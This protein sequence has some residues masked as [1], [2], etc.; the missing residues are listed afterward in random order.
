M[1]LDELLTGLR[2]KSDIVW[3][4][5][6]IADAALHAIR[7]EFDASSDLFDRH[8]A[9]SAQIGGT[10]SGGLRRMLMQLRDE[11][12]TQIRD[13]AVGEILQAFA[14]SLE[15]GW[16]AWLTK[17]AA[18][19]SVFHHRH[20]LRLCEHPFPFDGSRKQRVV[21]L[22]QAVECMLQSRWD[23][24]YEQIAFLSKQESLPDL[25]RARLVIIA[26]QIETSWFE[27]PKQAGRS[28]AEA[29]RLAPDDGL[30]LATLGD[31]WLGKDI[32]RAAAY[33]RR[34]METAP[35]SA[36]G[37][38][39]MGDR[40]EKDGRL[41]EAETWY[42]K[43]ISLAGGD[44]LGYN[45]LLRLLGR[46]ENLKSR[47]EEFL[48]LVETTLAVDPEGDY[49]TCLDTG[50][51]Y[52]TSGRFSEAGEWYDK[53]ISLHLNWPRAY[54]TLSALS[55]A[56]DNEEE[57]EANCKKAIEVAP[58]CPIGYL[59][60]AKI[61]EE[62]SRWQDALNIYEGSPQRSPQSASFARVMEG[63]MHAKLDRY[64][65]A[66]RILSEELRSDVESP[67]ALRAL[68]EIATDYDAKGGDKESAR[69]VYGGIREILGETYEGS[70][71][72]W[73]GNM[74]YSLAEYD[75][76]IAEYRRAIAAA[77]GEVVYHRNLANACEFLKDYENAEKA[78]ES[79][80]EIDNDKKL[81][82]QRR[83]G[84]ANA[85]GNDA[86][87]KEDYF[88]A[89]EQYTNAAVLDGTQAV[90]FTNCAWAWE[91][92]KKTGDR[93]HAL[94][95]A[96]RCYLRAQELPPRTNYA[97]PIARLRRRG[98]FA[99]AYGEKALDYLS[100]VTPIAVEV[101][102]D[103]VH[104]VEGG[105]EGGL[106]PELSANVSSMR[107]GVLKQLG[108][109]VPGIRFRGSETD[110]APGTYIVE[111]NEIPLLSGNLPPGCRFCTAS[112]E[113]LSCFGVSGRPVAD[114]ISGQAGTWIDRE[115]W[116]KVESAK[117]EL[118]GIT[119]YLMHHVEAELRKNLGEFLGHQETFSLLGSE[120]A[121]A[122]AEI[123]AS[124][125][126]VTALT[127][128]CQALVAEEVPIQPFEV[129]CATFKELSANRVSLCDVVEHIR[130]LP[131]FRE[132]L[133]GNEGQRSYLKLS[134][135]FEAEI[136][137]GIY[138][139]DGQSIL[140]MEPERCQAALAAVRARAV[141]RHLALVVDAALRP[142]VRKLVEL[143]FRDLPVLSS[144]EVRAEVVPESID[145][146]R[147]PA[148]ESLDLRSPRRVDANAIGPDEK[149]Q[150]PA[151]SEIEVTIFT[152]KDF[153]TEPSTA[154]NP[155]IG[156]MLSRMQDDLFY[157]LG[158]VLPQVK[159]ET[160][161]NWNQGEFRLRLNG[162][163]HGPFPGLGQDEFLVNDT[164]DRLTLL[165]IEG[166]GAVHPTNGSACAIVC[167][168][169]GQAATCRQAGLT[170]SGPRR[171]L[172]LTLSSEIRLAAARFQTDEVTQNQL[173]SLGESFPDLVRM[174]LERYTLPQISLLLRELLAEEISIRD[175]R[176]ILESLL[177]I[178]GTTDVD[179]SRFIV[180]FANTD[181]LCPAVAA[182]DVNA[183]TVT[184]LADFVRACLK[185]SISHK[186]TR[187]SNTLLVY[188]LDS[189]IEERIADTGAHPLTDEERA[190]LLKA[191]RGEVASLPPTAASPVLLTSFEVRRPLRK[192]IA[193]D[194]P[195]LAVL[196]YQDLSPD[197]NIQP[198]VRISWD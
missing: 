167:D 100:V 65:E 150:A 34:A 66:E 126:M 3:P 29:E 90:Y 147:T 148:A 179:L 79:A 134:T 172:V 21:E 156:E 178:G 19:V 16:R 143:E 55:Q 162:V 124:S 176:S 110:L 116:E 129:L 157:E 105:A 138:E 198:I 9:I 24:A 99:R 155:L 93:E 61:Y 70:Y 2:A 163:E 102:S 62:K 88:E 108:V 89:K 8:R 153:A 7:T 38:T 12:E 15:D 73:L 166:R 137:R 103:L 125:P 44:S 67:H 87:E 193:H 145:L 96:I 39:G 26:G 115:D 56:Q 171:H 191:I 20:S 17:L 37:Y 71:R 95:E 54:T 121:G 43:A 170:T 159:L 139:R 190:K 120:S 173:D 22:R 144:A 81:L 5:A 36:N 101:A 194:F 32:E 184:Q 187:G 63:R 136:R 186:Y 10:A 52:Q 45:Q 85:Q 183:L 18:A 130:G 28:Y 47:E 25:V 1:N 140:A 6:S 128:V 42:R 84:L 57:A 4:D 74:H 181:S 141:G 77:P 133:P 160:D 112:K 158:I 135:G 58:D 151:L 46:P 35:K 92:L 33:Y 13:T 196:S 80:C 119:K 189:A 91:R 132:R 104:C 152:G 53:A 123:R 64:Q 97:E 169:K 106:S 82:Q 23:E 51:Y 154:D 117:L 195:R 149:R 192:I 168:T 142:L 161:L 78:L 182:R 14:L 185:R 31:Y 86:Y 69:R 122:L 41:A 146:D 75:S 114:P 27:K 49:G 175:L 11:F 59:S 50:Q 30:V 188:L 118:W 94:Q 127:T 111:I 165:G 180:F 131:S 197:L 107:V 174:A 177:S 68:E 48:T 164:V 98:E 72:N 40:F 83:A 113:D 60:L 76:A 109:K